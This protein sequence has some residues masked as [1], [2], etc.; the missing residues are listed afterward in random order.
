[1][2]S[3]LPTSPYISQHLPTSPNISQVPSFPNFDS[4]GNA[5]LA[6]FQ[7]SSLDG[8]A[9]LLHFACDYAGID[10]QP[11]RESTYLVPTLFFLA[12]II[13]G[14]LFAANVFVGVVIDEFQSIKRIY[15]GSASLTEEQVIASD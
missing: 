12:F 13:F 2:S 4:T 15:D 10:V 9:S 14:V 1:M 3:H 7:V 11:A 6:L 5:L 8:W